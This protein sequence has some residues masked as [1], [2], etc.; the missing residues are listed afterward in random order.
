MLRRACCRW[1]RGVSD[2]ADTWSGETG[3]LPVLLVMR[4]GE[5]HCSLVAVALK[6]GFEFTG[7]DLA[8]NAVGAEVSGEGHGVV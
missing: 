3:F 2:A 8:F 6:S 1:S 5:D 7:T 4:A